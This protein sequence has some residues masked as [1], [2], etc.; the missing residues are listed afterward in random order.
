MNK[1]SAAADRVEVRHALAEEPVREISALAGRANRHD[2]VQPLNEQTQLL[3]TA[4]QASEGSGVRHVLMH[5]GDALAGYGI[6]VPLGDGSASAEAV[7]DPA[8]RGAGRGRALVTRLRELAAGSLQIWAHG[9]L[10]AAAAVAA[11]VG[12][13]RVRELRQLRLDLATELPAARVPP[14]VA[15]RAFRPGSDDSAW[16]ALNARAFAGHPEQGRLT[17][18]DLRRRQGQLWWDPAGF[19][20]AE[21]DGELVGFHWTKV[22]A[23][24]DGES[25]GEVYVIG[26]DP[27][28]QGGGLGRALTLTGLRHL[29]EQGLP[30]V[31][32]YVESDNAAA[33]ALYERLGFATVARDVMYRG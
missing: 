29:Q 4:D 22:H 19:F 15:V 23:D 31:L 12:F 27:G 11:A 25:V 9:D 10:P 28:A 30:A 32:L 26:V 20:V 14:G 21:R 24:V 3:L 18:R 16:V 5:D 13:K 2:Q 7:V 17:I 1:T 6:V 33:I 8:A